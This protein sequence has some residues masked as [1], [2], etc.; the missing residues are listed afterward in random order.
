MKGNGKPT[1]DD[2]AKKAGD[3]VGEF[4]CV[5]QNLDDG[6]YT[7]RAYAVNSKGTAYGDSRSF[8]I[9]SNEPLTLESVQGVYTFNGNNIDRDGEETIWPDL[10]IYSLTGIDNTPWIA[11]KGLYKGR[12]EFVALGKFD[13]DKQAIRLFSGWHLLNLTFQFPNND[14]LYYAYFRPVYW[15]E[16]ESFLYYM[17]KGDGYDNSA[18]AWFTPE[19]KNL[20]VYGPA[21]TPDVNGRFAN[22]FCFIFHTYVDDVSVGRFEA[23]NNVKLRKTGELSDSKIL[24]RPKTQPAVVSGDKELQLLIDRISRQL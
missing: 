6:E 17:Y 3:G 11:I 19:G 1:V 10:E 13:P 18:E 14:T 15:S 16:D 22:A 20:L 21:E 9:D 24:F 2:N 12:E 8:T 5:F 4:N 7:Y 23:Y